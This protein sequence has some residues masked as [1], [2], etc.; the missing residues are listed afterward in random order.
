MSLSRKRSLRW[1]S[2]V[3]TAMV[4]LLVSVPLIAEE[5]V[6]LSVVHRIRQAICRTYESG[7]STLL[8]PEGEK[9][10]VLPVTDV[11]NSRSPERLN[12]RRHRVAVPD[13]EHDAAALAHRC[14]DGGRVCVRV[15]RHSYHY[16]RQMEACGEWSSRFDRA[17]PLRRDNRVDASIAERA[18]QRLR[19]GAASL[20][21]RDVVFR[22][23]GFLRV[24]DD[25]HEL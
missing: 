5:A 9:Q 12:D 2:T 17:A 15:V 14:R 19:P 21:Q 10:P 8:D 1:K 22:R 3:A 11:G 13:D 18:D 25:D 6:D 7:G 20:A 16:R 4:G 23:L 24:P